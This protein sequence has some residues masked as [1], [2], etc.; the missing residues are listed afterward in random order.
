[1]SIYL[2]QII[3]Y[4]NICCDLHS[5]ESIITIESSGCKLIPFCKKYISMFRKYCN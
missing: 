5:F 4:A 2:E 3:L 1:M